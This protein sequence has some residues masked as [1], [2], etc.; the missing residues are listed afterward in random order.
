MDLMETP[1]G[2]GHLTTL[3]VVVQDLEAVAAP[4]AQLAVAAPEDQYGL[5]LQLLPPEH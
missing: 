1:E 5:M 2:L 3:T 4:E